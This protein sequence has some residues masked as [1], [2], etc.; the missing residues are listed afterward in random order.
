MDADPSIPIATIIAHIK[1]SLDTLWH[2][3]RLYWKC[4][5]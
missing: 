4:L 1:S 2:I 3:E 5:Q